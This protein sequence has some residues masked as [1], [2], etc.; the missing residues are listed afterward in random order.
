MTALQ[1]L[2]DAL[3][4]GLNRSVAPGLS[5]VVM[6]LY[7]ENPTKEKFAGATKA[8]GFSEELSRSIY[9]YINDNIGSLEA[10]VMQKSGAGGLVTK[11]PS[12]VKEYKEPRKTA[13]KAGKRKLTL[14]LRDG[15]EDEDGDL[16]VIPGRRE[17]VPGKQDAN[18]DGAK[19]DDLG[20]LEALDEDLGRDEKPRPKKITFKKI[21][22]EDAR[23]IKGGDSSLE[24][25]AHNEKHEAMSQ[26]E[27]VKASGSG[28]GPHQSSDHSKTIST[29]TP[30]LQTS[31][32]IDTTRSIQTTHTTHTSSLWQELSHR[33]A[34]DLAPDTEDKSENIENDRDWYTLEDST[35]AAVDQYLDLEQEY[36]PAKRI[37]PHQQHNKS[38]GGFSASG[39]YLDFD[40]DESQMRSRIPIFAHFIVP[41][42]L[43]GSEQH[44]TL[45][46]DSGRTSRS[47]GPSVDPI[48]DPE[49]ELAV[50]ART[51][52]F[53]IKDRKEKK[54]RARQAKDRV[55]ST[56]SSNKAFLDPQAKSKAESAEKEP[57][58]SD[59]SFDTIQQQRRSL[60]AYQSREELIK[61]V[62]ENQIVVVIGET[63][64][65]KTTQIAQFLAE[66]GYTKSLARD[67]SRL[68]IGCTQPRRVAAMS[69]AK[70]VSE[71]MGVKLGDDVGY[72]IRFE[73]KT[74]H[75][76]TRI[77]YMTEGIL[78]RELLE[79]PSLEQYSCIIMDEAHERSLNTDVLLGLF[80][81][82]LR[83]RRDLKLIVTSAT[84]NADRFT[85]YF[86]NAPQFFIPGRTFPVE[87]FYSKSRCMDYVETAVKQVV[88]IHLANKK[89]DGDILVFMTGQEDI[90]ATC[91][92]IHE[93]LSLLDNPPPLDV[94]PIYSTLPADLQKKIFTKQN[95]ERRK[96]VVATNI[97]ET[98]LT[99]DGIRYVV[100]CGLV[101]MKLFNPKL[102]MDALQ[103]VP[104]SM[105]NAQQRSGRAGRTG[106]G[107][108]YRLFTEAASSPDQM[109]AQP[110]P[111]IQR[112]NLSAVML[113]LKSLNV[114]D[115]MKF[116]FLDSPPLD[117]L[118]CSLYELWAMGALEHSGT[119][120]SL[121]S[122]MTAFPMEPT[123]AKLIILSCQ[124]EFHC[125]SEIVTIVAM[126]SVPSVF[127]RPKER[128]DEADA[129][130]ERFL[131]A[132]SDHLT[133][134]NVY[135]QWEQRAKTKN[136]TM[137]KL[138]AWSTRHFL[139]HKSL[140]RAKEVR[141][142]LEAIMAKLKYPMVKAKEDSDIR[143]CICA[144]YFHQSAS[145][146]KMSGGRGQAEYANLRQSYMKM[147]LHPTSALVGGADLSPQY[148]VYDELV[149][150]KKEYMQC[151]T[152]VEPEWLLKYG[153]VFYGVSPKVRKELEL[154]RGIKILDPSELESQMKQIEPEPT[155][156]KASTTKTRKMK[157]N[158]NF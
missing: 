51:G 8:L 153:Y 107:L 150:T 134:L 71:E 28:P 114:N 62:A 106:P 103:M 143:K 77:K 10:A 30:A 19:R 97:A 128:A 6:R 140:L 11:A 137:S 145:L 16:D 42:F 69:V 83:R 80:R 54:E 90:E 40:H 112:T 50:A 93:K 135:T 105:A 58:T 149:L 20:S 82:L 15:V 109:F 29:S 41:P 49:S 27:T 101:K 125:A 117:L 152:A 63:G 4:R 38:G 104:I 81:N 48:K 156:Q 23:R 121:G 99:V 129:M 146:E 57:E 52:S 136:M 26:S 115:I 12:L 44:L 64:S 2:A 122:K 13:P 59:Y 139:H 158:R 9:V 18:I 55:S 68:I 111:E 138:A 24:E 32:G 84:M 94:Y 34:G 17:L 116:P 144:A 157:V 95:S 73:D 86:G 142:Q 132:D 100:D 133:L 72:T 102:G 92:L 110:I 131:V 98:S 79:D 123:L 75:T 46:I 130:R 60:P 70:R 113:L 96:V 108:A 119:L 67:G 5:H 14:D 78:L 1:T 39:E 91:E 151:V 147:Y 37:R 36:K 88:T 87:V 120:T 21:K 47:V 89:G 74:S 127:N 25:A 7:K 118:T 22:K 141:T 76:K 85:R 65:G 126:L 155:Q 61:I 33:S 56:D 66:E 35:T 154:E 124:D 53:I 31:Q 43:R 3:S 148:V 45:Q